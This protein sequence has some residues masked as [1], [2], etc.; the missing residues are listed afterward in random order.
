MHLYANLSINIF[1]Y[2]WSRYYLTWKCSSAQQGNTV[3][4]L[5]VPVCHLSGWL[6]YLSVSNQY[7]FVCLLEPYESIRSMTICMRLYN[8]GAFENNFRDAVDWL[9]IDDFLSK[10]QL[11]GKVL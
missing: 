5:V 3:M 6:R 7:L 8:L 1:N 11:L 2:A 10:V 9:L 4:H